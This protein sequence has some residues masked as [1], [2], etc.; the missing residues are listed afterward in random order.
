MATDRKPAAAR[1]AAGFLLVAAG[2]TALLLL[3]GCDGSRTGTA[4]APAATGTAGAAADAP[5]A[6]TDAGASGIAWHD[7]DVD[8]AFAAATASGKPV[9]LYW[10]AEWCPDCKQLK[11][12]VFT[13][14][15]FVARTRLF[16]PVYLD[17]DLP[18]AQAWGDTFRVTGY[19]T[20]VILTP[21]RR[22][23]TRIAGGMDLN[24][25]ATA[26]DNALG[27]VRPVAEV[28]DLALAAEAPLGADDCRRLAYHGFGLEDADVFPP[29]LLGRALRN[30]AARCP[31]EPAALRVRLQLLAAAQAAVTAAAPGADVAAVRAALAGTSAAIA[32]DAAP[33]NIDVL[34]TFPAGFFAAARTADPAAA[35]VLGTRW[36]AV[37]RGAAADARYSPAD[38]LFAERLRVVAAA[39]LADDGKAPPA[40]AAA[41]LARAD[42]LLAKHPKG[43]VHASIVNAALMLYADLGEWERSRD[44]LKAEAATSKNAHYYLGHLAQVEEV[45]GNRDEALRLLG[46]AYARSAGTA[47]RAQWGYDYLRGLLRLSP[48]DTAA[49]AATGR[50]LL[51]GLGTRENVHR[52]TRQRLTKVG[53]E[54]GAWAT[55]PE[56]QTT[57][58]QLST[59]L[60]E[61][62]AAGAGPVDASCTTLWPAG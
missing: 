45:L 31:A 34:N 11:S 49:I 27:D 8:S 5:A 42:E 55:T 26:L 47:T 61:V 2:L 38:Q 24:L 60:G 51:D 48:D 1:A 43:F 59:R 52:R 20:L 18:G 19:P 21:D 25:Y 44:L 4:A 12:S 57:L 29:A 23:I 32:D 28:V 16:V 35:A 13:R 56:R 41:T 46:E 14:A 33:G 36:D 50:E 40:L 9:L 22:E 54:L 10:G 58:R 39:G 62:C 3:S 6:D 37:A 30:A 15:D 7:G 53:A 17:G